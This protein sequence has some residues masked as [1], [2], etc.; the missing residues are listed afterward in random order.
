MLTHAETGCVNSALNIVNFGLMRNRHKTEVKHR[1]K[2]LEQSYK[3]L[4]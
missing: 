3:E 1:L 2:T 4:K